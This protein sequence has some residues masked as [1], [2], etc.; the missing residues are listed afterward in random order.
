MS[1]SVEESIRFFFLSLEK[2]HGHVLISHALGY[3]T[4]AGPAGI[5]QAELEDVL[6]CDDEVL[7]DVYQW[8]T[9]PSRRLPPLLWARARNDIGEYLVEKGTAD[10]SGARVYSW[11]HRQFREVAEKMYLSSL[12]SVDSA[13]GGGAQVGQDQNSI[14]RARHRLLAMY[15]G[16]KLYEGVA[17]TTAK[18]V[19]PN[20]IHNRG[21]RAMRLLLH[22]GAMSE[23]SSHGGY[24][25]FFNRPCLQ[26]PIANTRRLMHQVYHECRAGMISALKG[27][28]GS[29]DFIIA[30]SVFGGLAH[31]LRVDLVD[32]L[33]MLGE[34]QTAAD[35]LTCSSDDITYVR[36]I[37]RF[38]QR[39]IGDCEISGMSWAQ[40]ARDEPENE[41]H[42]KCA[43]SAFREKYDSRASKEDTPS[44]FFEAC[45]SSALRMSSW[46]KATSISPCCM[47]LEGTCEYIFNLSLALDDS[48]IISV[49][50]GE[51]NCSVVEMWSTSN[52]EK[53]RR[54][55][56]VF[57]F[58]TSANGQVAAFCNTDSDPE[59]DMVYSTPQSRISVFHLASWRLLFSVR[60]N[61]KL[62]QSSQDSLLLNGSGSVLLVLKKNSF[63]GGGDSDEVMLWNI[64]S[65]QM[66]GIIR[67]SIP[68]HSFSPLTHRSGELVVLAGPDKY[69]M[70]GYRFV[71]PS[72]NDTPLPHTWEFTPGNNGN[73]LRNASFSDD[74]ALLSVDKDGVMYI[75][76]S[77]NGELKAIIP[78]GGLSTLH[79]PRQRLFVCKQ[80]RNVKKC[81]IICFSISGFIDSI[82]KECLEEAQ[83]SM[84]SNH[85]GNT[86]GV[87][88]DTLQDGRDRVVGLVAT[89]T[90]HIVT[91]DYEL[92]VRYMLVS[93]DGR[94]L[95]VGT[96]TVLMGWNIDT[97]ILCVSWSGSFYSSL[98]VTKDMT[99]ISSSENLLNFWEDSRL[100]LG[101]DSSV[102]QEQHWESS[103]RTWQI[104]TQD[105]RAQ[106]IAILSEDIA[107]PHVDALVLDAPSSSD[108]A[109]NYT[110]HSY[111]Y[112][113]VNGESLKCNVGLN[114]YSL[115]T[116]QQLHSICVPQLS[117][118]RNDM[119]IDSQLSRLYIS[120]ADSV[121]YDDCVI[122]YDLQAALSRYQHSEN[123]SSDYVMEVFPC[124]SRDTKD[125]PVLALSGNDGVLAVG[126]GHSIL[127]FDTS[128]SPLK[129]R[130]TLQ[131]H[132]SFI[133][134]IYVSFDGL[135]V[136][137]TAGGQDPKK[138]VRGQGDYFR[139]QFIVWEG[140]TGAIART[141][142]S[143]SAGGNIAL[144]SCGDFMARYTYERLVVVEQ[145]RSGERVWTLREGL[146][147]VRVGCW[148]AWACKDS[149][150]IGAFENNAVH[151]WDM[152]S[153]DLKRTVMAGS[154]V[155]VGVVECRGKD[156]DKH[157]DTHKNKSAVDSDALIYA[158]G[159]GL[160]VWAVAHI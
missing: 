159:L 48:M 124:P 111:M 10:N 40:V 32:V 13:H 11:Y 137:S 91:T 70:R 112:S 154:G 136:V 130:I 94:L 150:L 73:S 114:I 103:Y 109:G 12:S 55:S 22:D 156:T 66:I 65:K 37:L 38:I 128:R 123:P 138:T 144:T 35:S 44:F 56:D 16:D 88:L 20:I 42:V 29:L 97:G 98:V 61:I 86:D 117:N 26:K 131:G 72:I 3:I 152:R 82:G 155:H 62:F 23:C 51:S 119:V 95:L 99:I 96:T 132:I 39:H 102:Y 157:T 149:L 1:A 34:A 58:S 75:L 30:K 52:G 18:S 49:G 36:Q 121:T 158:R 7:D 87:P 6:S 84:L 27:S 64:E 143:R 115:E 93:P 25:S 80:Q 69:T 14:R 105:G 71:G 59:E 41:V 118:S 141:G 108:D 79:A 113:A 83:C 76:N 54:L 47:T 15:F 90:R 5:S 107:C 68:F 148:L 140:K 145:S 50:R 129:P 28:I 31:L 2:I 46:C 106:L 139:T 24:D 78:F 53:I 21:V 146:R 127:L 100:L 104:C 120:G 160:Q 43:L 74:E 101:N 9:P 122:I 151:F 147:S 45:E 60:V 81:D 126:V 92:D 17:H 89:H 8:W 110:N 116:G 125:C 57:F 85:M 133:E 19:N 134:D 4:C 63:F 33:A 135:V 153:G 77:G 67:T 142:T